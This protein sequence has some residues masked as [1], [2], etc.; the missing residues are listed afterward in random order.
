SLLDRQPIPRR[1]EMSLV[2]FRTID[3]QR[4]NEPVGSDVPDFETPVARS[5]AE[6]LFQR[7]PPIH[8][9]AP[10]EP[11]PPARLRIL[12]RVPDLPRARVPQVPSFAVP[13]EKGIWHLEA[14]PDERCPPVSLEG[15]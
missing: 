2:R 10:T 14:E 13:G 8:V 1:G 9:S 12:Q 11:P 15:V 4:A 5:R 6:L 7:H 3:L